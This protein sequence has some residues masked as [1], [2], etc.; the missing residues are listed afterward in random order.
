MKDVMRKFAHEIH[1]MEFESMS[2]IPF[3]ELVVEAYKHSVYGSN[4]GA[5]VAANRTGILG[6]NGVEAAIIRAL[7]NDGEFVDRKDGRVYIMHLANVQAKLA[8]RFWLTRNAIDSIREDIDAVAAD[9][10]KCAAKDKED[11]NTEKDTIS[12]ADEIK[13]PCRTCKKMD[14]RRDVG[15]KVWCELWDTAVENVVQLGSKEKYDSKCV[16]TKYL[17][18][19]QPDSGTN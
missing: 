7:C 1:P 3:K 4:N 14:D 18:Q 6:A 12:T 17:T 8:N 16:A 5:V 15:G 13:T 19:G 10:S 2:V 11:K 9:L